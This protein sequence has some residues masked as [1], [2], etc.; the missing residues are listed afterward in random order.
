MYYIVHECNR[1]NL[2][3]AS[4]SCDGLRRDLQKTLIY[5]KHQHL[6]DIF[7]PLVIGSTGYYH[8]LN[9]NLEPC[10]ATHLSVFS[11]ANEM[12]LKSSCTSLEKT[13]PIPIR[14][15]T[16]CRGDGLGPKSLRHATVSWSDVTSRPPSAPVPITATSWIYLHC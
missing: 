1:L 7:K 3:S 4:C 14:F 10:T 13:L 8:Q 6:D 2:P 12:I 15:Q 16:L 9:A 11:F 5:I